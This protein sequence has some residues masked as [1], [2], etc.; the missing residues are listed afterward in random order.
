MH[1]PLTVG[2]HSIFI[3][4][5]WKT[6]RIACTKQYMNTKTPVHQRLMLNDLLMPAV[7]NIRL[8]SNRIEV[9]MANMAGLYKLA[10]ASTSYGCQLALRPHNE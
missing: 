3:G 7:T 6:V 8:Y 5:Q 4:L 9:L 2:S 1:V 10:F